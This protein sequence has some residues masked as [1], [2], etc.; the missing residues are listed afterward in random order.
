LTGTRGDEE[1]V[2]KRAEKKVE[3]YMGVFITNV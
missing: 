2:N 1:I 3:L